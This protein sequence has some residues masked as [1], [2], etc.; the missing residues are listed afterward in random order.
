MA[1]DSSAQPDIKLQFPDLEPVGPG[2]PAGQYLRRFWHP[3]FRARDLR[4]KQAKPIE[5]LSEKFTLYRG[6]D[7]I[8]RVTEFRCP[9]RGTQMSIGWV[10]GD[11]IRCRY[12]GWRYDG[13]GQCVEQPNEEHPFCANVK[14]RTYPTHEYLGL[15]FAYLGDGVPGSFPRYADFDLPGTIVT[16]PPEVLPCSFWNRLDNDA[17]HVPWVHRTTAIRENWNHYLV[18]R[19]EEIEETSYGYRSKRVPG[20]GED[21]SALGMREFV[22]FFMPNAFQFYQRT[23][24]KGYENK[25]W[26]DTKITWTVPV[27][28]HTYV[29]FDV[30]RTPVDGEEGLAYAADRYA[31]MD[32]E[33]EVRWDI[34]EKILAGEMSLDELPADMGAA[35]CFIIEDYVTQVGQGSVRGRGREHLGKGDVKPVLLRRIYNREITAMLQS[36]PMKDWEMPEKPFQTSNVPKAS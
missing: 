28:D 10:E 35:T 34:A 6:E 8:A 15:I 18:L 17:G 25:T 26:W 16:D 9:H 24:A 21:Q 3:V 2:T 30:T 33:G 12:H 5:I 1:P 19:Q 20:K 31:Q 36:Q 7:G 11:S 29:G 32:A 27:N 13:T 22:H 4:P 23:R 14:L